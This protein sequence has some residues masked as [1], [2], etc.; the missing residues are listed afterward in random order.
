MQVYPNA[1]LILEDGSSFSGYSFGAPVSQDGEVVFTTGMVGYPESLTDP[2]FCGQILVCTYPL[3]GNYGV[4]ENK[5]QDGIS[6][7]FESNKIQVQ[8]L[9]VAEY[10]NT[11]FHYQASKTLRQWLCEQNVPAIGGIDTRAL[12][13]KL[14][15]KGVMLGRILIS[16]EISPFK[17]EE[18]LNQ[19][20]SVSPSLPPF[21]DPNQHNLVAQVS[22]TKPILYQRGQTKIVMIDCGVKNNIIR[23]FLKRDITV[24]RVPWDYDFTQENY[25]GIFISNGPGDPTQCHTTIHNL[26]KALT[27]TKP[28][29]GICLGSQIMALAAGAKTYKL[30]YGHRG[31]NQPCLDTTTN[32]CYITSQNH[33]Y[34]VDENTLST[35]WEP[36]LTNANDGSNEGIRHKTKPFFAVQFHPE[37]APGPTDTQ[38]YF[39]EFIEM[40]Q[41]VKK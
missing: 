23:E 19:K 8:G 21:Q 27:Q 32:R 5:T 35:D 40:I 3:I 11:A 7:T 15:E 30:K 10:S 22:C 16:T 38:F 24:I 9:I 31:Q 34:A 4:P 41:K 20:H 14:R 36:F 18:H 39:D 37:A 26:Q 2:S 25:D 33:G 28:I 1:K 17:Q 13:K 6:L 12:T 29:F